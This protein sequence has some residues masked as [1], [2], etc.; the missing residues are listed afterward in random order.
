MEL[1]DQMIMQWVGQFFWP[2]TRVG[3]FFTAMPLFGG[4]LIPVRARLIL[5]ILLTYTIVPYLPT[6]PQVGIWSFESVAIIAN[7]VLIGAALGFFIQIFFQVFQ[8]AGQFIAMQNGLGFATMIDPVNGISVAAVGQ[9]FLLMSNLLFLALGGHLIVIEVMISSFH[10]MPIHESGHHIVIIDR[11]MHFASWMFRA[12]VLV[13]LPSVT[14]LLISNLAFGLMA[15][16]A[17]QMNI[18]SIGFP[19]NMMFGLVVLWM[20]VSQFLPIY[21]SVAEEALSAAQAL[22]IL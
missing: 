12:A 21:E 20:M 2:F 6:P 4:R 11:M 17:P 22:L 8:I 19:F 5:A 7:Q 16:V 10:V 1:T 3:A 9:I 14:A 18:F 15:R 13:A